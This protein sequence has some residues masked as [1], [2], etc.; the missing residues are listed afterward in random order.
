MRKLINPQQ[1]QRLMVVV[2]A[3]RLHP[4]TLL[5]SSSLPLVGGK[6]LL[7]PIPWSSLA[8]RYALCFLLYDM[9]TFAGIP[10]S[11]VQEAL[12]DSCA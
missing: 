6:T 12:N 1:L 3:S 7:L 2:T 11:L 8:T 5:K 10:G 9:L 4:R